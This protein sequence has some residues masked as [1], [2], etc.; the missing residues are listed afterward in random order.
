MFAHSILQ[1]A[2]DT[3]IEIQ[4]VAVFLNSV[5]RDAC[6]GREDEKANELDNPEGYVHP[7]QPNLLRSRH[8]V[9]FLLAL[10]M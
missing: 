6:G 8:V 7:L 10:L 1:R 3:G 4:I 5:E 2:L 9:G